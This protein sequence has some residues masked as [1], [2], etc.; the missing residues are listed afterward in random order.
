MAD[1]RKMALDC[2]A[3]EPDKYARQVLHRIAVSR[4][5]QAALNAIS[6]DEN[7]V[8]GLIQICINAEMRTRTF[9]ETLVAERETKEQLQRHRKS[10]SDLR[11]FIKRATRWR[12]YL[13]VMP[14]S[15]TEQERVERQQRIFK[16]SEAPDA[17]EKTAGYYR[18]ALNRIEWLI[19]KRQE[20]IEYTILEF[21]VTRKSKAKMAAENSGIGFLVNRVATVVG[22][23]RARHVAALAEAVLGISGVTEN[24][25][26]EAAKM[27]R[28]KLVYSTNK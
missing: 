17:Y 6:K 8:R 20:L 7:Q 4:D 28:R 19:D 18:E 3:S 22:K 26:R 16:H 21:G 13:F 23:P 14:L 9:H 11:Q 10:V 25:V 5:A 2:L 1:I 27:H 12:E 15:E 24:R